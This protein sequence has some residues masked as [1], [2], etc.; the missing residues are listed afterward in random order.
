M[1][2]WF[3]VGRERFSA[4]GWVTASVLL[5]GVALVSKGLGLIRDLLTAEYFGAKADVDAFFFALSV[6]LL[7]GSGIGVAL[8]A[9]VV[10]LY[11]NLALSGRGDASR[12]VTVHMIILTGGLSLVAVAPLLL[13]AP[14]VVPWLAAS[15]SEGLVATVGAVLPWL[16]LYVVGQN[17]VFVQS[18]VFEAR[19]HFIIPAVS[20]LAFNVVVILVLLG[21]SQSWGIRALAFGNVLGTT[22]CAGLLFCFLAAAGMIGLPGGTPMPDH[23]RSYGFAFPIMLWEFGAQV[24]AVAQNYYA[25]QLPE[26]HVAA[27]NYAGRI[28]VILVALLALN[29]SRGVFP[30]L[31]ALW[32]QRK[33]DE[34][35]RILSTIGK[36]MAVVFVPLGLVGI[37][38]GERVLSWLYVRGVF[39]GHAL[40]LTAMAFSVYCAALV[41]GVLEPVL[42]KACYACSDSR[43]PMMAM[44]GSEF[45]V[46]AG[47]PVVTSRWGI[48]GIAGLANA[49]LCARVALLL[50]V[51]DRRLGGATTID[52]AKTAMVAGVCAA[53]ACVLSAWLSVRTD[54]EFLL[55]MALYS[56]TYGLFAWFFL[57]DEV[58]PYVQRVRL[59][60]GRLC[61]AVPRR[62][63]SLP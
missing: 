36:Q 55:W 1:R 24:I 50:L 41:V 17:V 38:H 48:A 42:L 7:P 31:S 60:G 11:Q 2:E 37:L 28:S 6:A 53:G 39:D 46:V 63:S 62:W 33:R 30:T 3:A 40:H 34:A 26:G 54:L 23:W 15:T 49:V 29:I 12:R 61:R 14:S 13:F 44:I 59:M 9:M 25:A 10:P 19:H 56:V 20:D 8:S 57:A 16:C 58:R 45:L 5:V 22:A 27:L 43:T 35:S 4:Q 51:L 21:L 47:L 18:A 32:L 52:V